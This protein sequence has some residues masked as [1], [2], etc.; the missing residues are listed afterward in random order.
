MEQ[1]TFSLIPQK[2]PKIKT[3]F[4]TVKTLLPVPQSIPIIEDAMRYES[5]SMHD[6][7]PIIWNKAKDF[8]VFDKYGN[9][10]IDFTSTIFVMN[11]GHS[12]PKVISALKKSI[13]QKLLHSY[14]FINE[15]RTKLLKKL[16]EITP[17]FCEKSFLLSSGTEATECAIK[18]MR[19]YGQKN[20]SSKI[21]IISFQDSMHGRTMG[22]EM[23]RNK[24]SWIG[25]EDPNIYRLPSASHWLKIWHS[26]EYDGEEHF[27]EDIEGLY[28]K[29]MDV[30][31]IAGFMIEPYQ[32]WSAFFFQ[33]DYI[34]ALVRFA[35]AHNILVTFDEI[36]GGFGRTGKLFA[37]QHYDVEP[38]LLCLGKGLSGGIP[39]SAV[40]GR[41][42]IM[43]ISEMGSMSST[44]S[45]NPIS[46]AIGLANIEV[47]QSQNLIKKSEEKGKILHQRLNELKNKYPDIISHI[48][49][50]GLLAAIHIINPK[51]QNSDSELA[52]KI[53]EKCMQ[54]GLLVVHT[55]RESI[56]IGPPLT[57]P[58]QVMIEGINVIEETIK[59]CN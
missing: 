47:M 28:K 9:K 1:Y 34:Q 44:H 26:S 59:E 7:L 56:K 11:V 38:D 16:N 15:N 36:Q 32:G 57:I 23:L 27:Q 12:N 33:K 51:T 18:L 17:D 52:S 50:K 30:D 48:F 4:R 54:K 22:A 3:R 40:V 46:C 13:N 37:Y 39:L 6:Q 20:D 58:I 5:K 31:K 14:T 10:W 49:G 42:E 45:G 19:M 55:G 29:G 21:G 43:D 41:Q 53:C 2:V 35:N 8:Q 24:S 25:Y